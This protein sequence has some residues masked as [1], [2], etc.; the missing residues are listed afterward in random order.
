MQ[1]AQR[2]ASVTWAWLGMNEFIEEHVTRLINI[3]L[4]RLPR[5][6]RRLGC[7]CSTTLRVLG[8]SVKVAINFYR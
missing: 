5:K 2:L 4:S 1:V 7:K 6:E 8:R 3:A